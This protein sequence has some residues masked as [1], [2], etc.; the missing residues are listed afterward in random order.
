MVIWCKSVII[1]RLLNILQEQIGRATVGKF[2]DVSQMFTVKPSE[3][4]PSSLH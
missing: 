3:A 1:K 2:S 4:Y